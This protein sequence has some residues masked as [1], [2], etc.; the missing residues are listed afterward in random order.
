VKDV[1]K[2]TGFAR[3]RDEIEARFSDEPR[4]TA[5]IPGEVAGIESTAEAYKYSNIHNLPVSMGFCSYTTFLKSRNRF[6]QNHEFSNK[7]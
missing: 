5:P 3:L 1:R 6:S 4:G 7:N 2:K